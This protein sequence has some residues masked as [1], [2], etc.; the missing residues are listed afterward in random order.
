MA[1]PLLEVSALS[2]SFGGNRVLD[3]LSFSVDAGGIVGVVGPNGS[4]KTT[5][6]NL[7]GGYLRHDR[8]RVSLAGGRISG[9]PP[10]RIAR[11]GIG[12]T[13]QALRVFREMTVD[14]NLLFPA[15]VKAIPDPH[16]RAHELLEFVGLLAHRD[17]LAG[18][19]SVGQQRL[20][21]FAMVLM[22]RPR[23][24]ML[25]EPI[26]GVNPVIVERLAEMIHALR[27]DGLTFLIVEHNVR[28]VNALCDRVVV[29]DHGCKIA[30]GTPLELR[31]NAAVIEAYLGKGL[32]AA[33]G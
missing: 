20:L 13:F 12:R 31:S 16:A 17:A 2:K 28:F 25:D 32:N 33:R 22:A 11:L 4:G 10:Y 23:L 26:A 27:Q 7:I 18:H 19:L 8:G 9:L 21:E 3:A 5:L 29:L 14:E 6:F 15:V 30:E 24:I 1:P